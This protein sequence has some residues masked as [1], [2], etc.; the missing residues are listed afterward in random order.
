MSCSTSSGLPLFGCC[1]VL[2]PT[3]VVYHDN[4]WADYINTSP[5]PADYFTQ[6]VNCVVGMPY[7][8]NG[9]FILAS[10]KGGNVWEV[11]YC[12]GAPPTLST[13]NVLHAY[14]RRDWSSNYGIV[15]CSVSKVRYANP[16]RQTMVVWRYR[17]R[18]GSARP[19]GSEIKEHI[20]CR[21]TT[22]SHFELLPDLAD[23]NF[24]IPAD[25]T[26]YSSEVIYQ[27]IMTVAE[28]LREPA[29]FP[30]SCLAP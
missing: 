23:S 16:T 24:P 6:T 25:G 2:L 7:V 10:Y 14:I 8:I 13:T 5:A 11:P 18:F 4:N 22:E 26:R 1:G 21:L 28:A 12:R 15:G 27:R 29:P 20:S 17:G 9:P 3:A 30:Q 19:D